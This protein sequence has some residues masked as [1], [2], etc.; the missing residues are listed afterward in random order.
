MCFYSIYF[1]SPPVQ[2]LGVVS[3]RFINASRCVIIIINCLYV[4]DSLSSRLGYFTV[5]T[6]LHT[7]SN[8]LPTWITKFFCH[9]MGF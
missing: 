6:L 5:S 8:K 7:R 9:E 4:A 1:V 2:V 3:H